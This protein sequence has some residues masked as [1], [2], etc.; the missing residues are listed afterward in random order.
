MRR[1]P[2]PSAPLSSLLRFSALR[3]SALLL[4]GFL[5]LS[6]A[7]WLRPPE[8]DEAYSLFL[9]A[10]DPRPA[11]PGGIFMAGEVR[12]LYRG[13]ASP[14]AIATALRRGDVH[15]PLYFWTLEY[16][17]RLFGPSWLAARM[18]SVFYATA[19]LAGLAVLAAMAGAAPQ[20]ALPLALLSYGF[21][22][23]GIVARGFAL[24]QA[25]NILGLIFILA[26]SR[27]RRG[28]YGLAAGLAFGAAS[29]TNYLAAFTALAG[30]GWLASHRR[31][32][33]LL[34]PALL[35]YALFLPAVL[36]FYLPQRNSRTGQ[37]QPFHLAHALVLLAKDSGA[38]LFGGLPVYAGRAGGAVTAALLLLALAAAGC[39]VRNWRPALG[40]FGLAVLAVPAGLLALG[41][42]FNN[43]PIEIRYLAFAIPPLAVLLAATLPRGLR[44]LL[45][46]VQACGFAGLML[47]PA[48]MQ[49]QG[50]AARAAARFPPTALVL[51]PFGNDGV[52]V[53]GP[54]IAAAPDT[55]R[56]QLLRPGAPPV[57]QNERYLLLATLRADAASR[58]AVQ[59]ALAR[60]R[61]DPCWKPTPLSPLLTAFS[62]VCRDG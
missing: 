27:R 8:Y 7:A 4:S 25:L 51:L 56:L 1:P 37:F 6:L 33:P 55:L 12:P 60:L 58:Q 19:A 23:T 50:L 45:L 16:W 34:W 49:P 9:T 43:T 30:F 40:L 42:L 18:L 2:P 46:A 41:L 20:V 14:G 32:R 54:F 22:Y 17:R 44:L 35:G 38:A 53:P 28:G 52:G 3:F 62:R 13:H 10:G 57:W 24:A 29:F 15:P 31:R 39:V 36:S 5:L 21:A 48:T 61:A 11:W 26:A 47:A 59:S